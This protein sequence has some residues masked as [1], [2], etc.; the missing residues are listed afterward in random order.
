MGPTPRQAQYLDVVVGVSGLSV[1]D[2]LDP[3]S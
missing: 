1:V 2:L 3:A